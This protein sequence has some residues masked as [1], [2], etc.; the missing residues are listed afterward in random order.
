MSRQPCPHRIE[1]R[2]LRNVALSF[3]ALSLTVLGG[4]RMG[5]PIHVWSPAELQST[6]GKSVLVPELVGPKAV[7]DPI[8]EQLVQS[9][10]TGVGQQTQL[11]SGPE[12]LSA[13]QS[14]PEQTIALV[15]YD[16]NDT[17][18]LALAEAA[19]RQNI[20]FI[21]RGEVLPDR[22]PRQ[23]PEAGQRISISWRLTP[24]STAATA[25]AM[26]EAGR[27]VVVDL[28]AALERY[29]DL[30][31]LSDPEQALQAAVVRQTLPLITPSV[32]RGRVQLEIPYL[33]PGTK[34]I[35]RGNAL[36][37]AGRWQA[38]EE[39]WQ[40][41]QQRYPFSS[42]AVHNLAVAAAARQDFSTA[43]RLARKAVRMKPSALHK[44]TLIWIERT[45][46]DY[47]EAFDLPDPPEG[48][49]L[50]RE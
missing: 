29:P 22:R 3:T 38:A 43:K 47:H 31:L 23:I 4:C 5:V 42:V 27:P 20:D 41:V 25:N 6:V 32:R 16:Q 1:R 40:E 50:T 12:V 35:R 24:V 34:A 11:L 19:R 15:S 7:T 18:D 21:L 33:L 46:R 2:L 48:W 14:S 36:A 39:A 37:M 30:G 8:H 28:Q 10:P 13:L 17:S 44:E 45:Q 49:F 26:A 9:A